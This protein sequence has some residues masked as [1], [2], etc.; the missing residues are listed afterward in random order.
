MLRL[1]L[2]YQN[3][4]NNFF[5]DHYEPISLIMKTGEVPPKN[6]CFECYNPPVF[7]VIGAV[8][9]N[10]LRS[11]G[12]DVATVQKTLQFQN[13]FYN[14]LTLLVVYLILMKFPFLSPFSRDTAFAAACFLP[15]HIYMAAIFSNDNLT[16][17]GVALCTY[18][19]LAAL[20]F[21]QSWR[22]AGVLL[23][24]AAS[25][26]IFAKYTGFVVLPMI[27]VTCIALAARKPGEGSGKPL[28]LMF[29]ALLPP[30][31][32]LGSYMA[33]NYKD[34]GEALPWNE[35]FLDTGK[36]QPHDADPLNFFSFTPWS[37]LR[38]PIQTPGQLHSFWTLIYTNTWFDTEPKFLHYTDWNKEWWTQYWSWRTGDSPFPATQPPLTTATR[39]MA[40]GLLT[41]G[42]IP[43]FLVV[44]GLITC[45]RELSARNDNWSAMGKNLP[46]IILLAGNSAIVV[47]LVLKAPVFSSM[48]ASYFLC[49]LPAFVVLAARGAQ[50]FENKPPARYLL[51]L[52]SILIASLAT[53][54]VMHIAWDIRSWVY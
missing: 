7:Y 17:L 20:E 16:Y 21:K 53:V 9:A 24:I 29:I 1:L 25:L 50:L 33:T 48:K 22:V 12:L 40:A 46:L 28:R 44:A 32:L 39:I 13:C 11:L 15:R 4:P 34:Y 3:P 42:L 41:V 19:M 10:A 5:D 30:L 35:K 8:S 37:Y 38:E 6:A 54:H 49:S 23:G 2:C 26:A 52:S 27:A 43:L 18:L 47:A 36:I 14:I 45:I 51:I 31:L